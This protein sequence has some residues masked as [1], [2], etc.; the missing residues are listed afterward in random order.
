MGRG[1]GIRTVGYALCSYLLSGYERTPPRQKDDELAEVRMEGEG[2]RAI[3]VVSGR[4]RA[5][6][7]VHISLKYNIVYGFHRDG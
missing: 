6:P 7:S 2:V 4:D 5:E 3:T 1:A